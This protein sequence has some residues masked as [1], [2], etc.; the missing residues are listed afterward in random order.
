MTL[1]DIYLLNF[2][3]LS[4]CCELQFCVMLVITF[5]AVV[6]VRTV[7]CNVVTCR[8]IK[9]CWS[10]VGVVFVNINASKCV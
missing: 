6:F 2:L 9:S 1:T 3:A 10:F 8:S 4:F 7:V 5:F